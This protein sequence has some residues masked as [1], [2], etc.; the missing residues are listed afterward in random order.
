MVAEWLSSCTTKWMTT[1]TTESL[2]ITH[3]DIGPYVDEVVGAFR[4]LTFKHESTTL[5]AFA[6]TF[7]ALG[8]LQAAQTMLDV[9][10]PHSMI[11][12]GSSAA[13]ATLLFAAPAAPL[14]TP[15]NTFLG[16]A[17]SISVALSFH[18]LQQ[19]TGLNL[20]VT[21]LVPSV[22][23]AI[24]AHLK[25]TNPPAAAA[26]F[27][28]TI[29]PTAQAQPVGGLVVPAFVGCAWL[30]F[31]QFLV[32]RA[33]KCLKERGAK[34]PAAATPPKSSVVVS[35]VDPVVAAL[36]VQAVEGAAY[37]DDP[38]TFMIDTLTRDRTNLKR[39][40]DVLQAFGAKLPS[41]LSQNGAASLLQKRFRK[42]AATRRIAL[43][44]T[45]RKRSEQNKSWQAT[46]SMV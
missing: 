16:H 34:Q 39:Q 43:S 40:R 7:M 32:H 9:L 21:V 19:L 37:V 23:I 17:V 5:T 27:I 10:A 30:V 13:L 8:G 28:F 11:L 20:I 1:T 3:A 35:T 14:G 31:C 41:Y 42:V 38:L 24:M 15:W 29:T 26:A 33:L 22:A 36:I 46:S 44:P 2:W 18:W 4:S 6:G 45:R 25:I 12:I